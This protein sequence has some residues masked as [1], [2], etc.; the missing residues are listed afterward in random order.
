MVKGLADG[1]RVVFDDERAVANAGVLLPAVLAGRRLGIEALVD[2]AVDLGDRAGR[3]TRAARGCRWCRR[4]RSGLTASTTA[5]CCAR[6]R[7]GRCGVIACPRRRRSGRFC[8][9]SRSGM[10]AS[11]TGCWLRACLVRGRRLRGR[12]I[13]AWSW[14]S[15]RLSARCM[16]MTSRTRAM[17]IR[18]SG[19]P[20]DHRDQS[21]DRRGVAHPRQEGVREHVSR[22]AAV[23]RR[24]DPEGP[25]GRS[26]RADVVARGLGVL[27]HED[28]GPVAGRGL[29]VLDR[30]APAETHQSRDHRDPRAGLAD[31]QRLPRRRGSADRADDARPPAA[32]HP[33]HPTDR[34][35]SRTVAG[36]AALRIPHQP[37]PTRS[38]RSKRSTEDTRSWNSRS[39]TSKTKHSHTSPPASSSRTPPGP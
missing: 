27:E 20:P 38:S 26:D 16:A 6:V 2:R 23:R 36:L 17:G 37:G 19:V 32:D 30:S 31:P 25:A 33:A 29:A 11:S 3:R 12:A 13:S 14:M 8:A 35:P 24:T 21:R 10:S 28:H 7:R 22:R 1:A 39:A 34:C 15:I 5:T 9:R 18:T 4:W